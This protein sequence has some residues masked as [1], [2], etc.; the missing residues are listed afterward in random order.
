MKKC[1]IA[2]LALSVIAGAAWAGEQMSVQVRSAFVKSSPSFTASTVGQMNYGTPVDVMVEKDNWAQISQPSGWV[3]MSALTTHNT[4]NVS[5]DYK[6]GKASSDEVAL[7]G[8]GFNPKV[9]AE[10]KRSNSDLAAAYVK[11]DRV[12]TFTVPEATLAQFAKSGNLSAR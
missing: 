12:E 8:K 1:I 6:G 9:E 3:H 11:V 10:F 7:A 5:T 2:V 4:G